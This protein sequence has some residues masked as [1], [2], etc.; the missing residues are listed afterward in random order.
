[1]IPLIAF[2]TL[3]KGVCNEGETFQTTMYPTKHAKTKTVMCERNSDEPPNPIKPRRIIAR[4]IVIN[5]IIQ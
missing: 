3:I 2:V 5:L 1:M 4:K